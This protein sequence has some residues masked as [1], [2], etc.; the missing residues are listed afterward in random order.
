ML[1]G[2]VGFLFNWN[3]GCNMFF[4]IWNSCIKLLNILK[5][6]RFEA[7]VLAGVTVLFVLLIL[8]FSL[9]YVSCLD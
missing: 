8:C 7:L 1:L 9:T 6:G 5:M 2:F 4:N 3:I